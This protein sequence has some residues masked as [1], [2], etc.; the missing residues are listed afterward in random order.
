MRSY[1]KPFLVILMLVLTFRLLS[2]LPLAAMNKLATMLYLGGLS[3]FYLFYWITRLQK[4]KIRYID[5]IM[6]LSILYVF[7]TAF[8]AR[9]VFG[10]PLSNGILTQGSHFLILSSLL[11]Y[12]LLMNRLISIKSVERGLFGAGFIMICIILGFYLFAD[13]HRFAEYDFVRLQD[14][15]G[16]VYKFAFTIVIFL[17][18]Y[19]AFRILRKDF[20]WLHIAALLLSFIYLFAYQQ[21]RSVI[22]ALTVTLIIFFAKNFSFIKNVKYYL[23]F[24]G[25]LV[26]LFI[27]GLVVDLQAVSKLLVLFASLMAGSESEE[28]SISVRFIEMQ[29]A[30]EYIRQNPILGNGLLDNAWQGGFLERFGHFYLPDIG[31]VGN[32]FAY[33]IVGVLIL[34]L[35]MIYAYIL[36]RRIGKHQDVL[37]HAS[38]YLLVYLFIQ[39]LFRASNFGYLAELYFYV[40]IVFFYYKTGIYRQNTAIERPADTKTQLSQPS[41]A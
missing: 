10:Q 41:R 17:F 19:C 25:G 31:I 8:Q 7:V 6:L 32:L 38:Q 15:Q 27:I 21:K 18:L 39:M 4:Q 14:F 1:V 9:A 30:F 33:G 20:N 36:S 11:I 16:V 22:I 12:T 28:A 35:P 23:Y 2:N 34:Y 13:P 24:A 40:F 37:L 3:V 26:V 5:V 29:I